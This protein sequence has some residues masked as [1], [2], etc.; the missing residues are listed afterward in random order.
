MQEIYCSVRYQ[1]GK[2]GRNDRRTS[3]TLDDTSGKAI[4]D[5]IKSTY[6][7][8]IGLRNVNRGGTL[9]PVGILALDFVAL[10]FIQE[11]RPF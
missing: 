6:H 7:W 10:F 3:K 11:E 4:Q 2:S 8:G 1:V 5:K 9:S